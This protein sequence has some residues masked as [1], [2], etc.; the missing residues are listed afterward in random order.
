[1]ERRI[2]NFRLRIDRPQLLLRAALDIFTRDGFERGRLE[3][4][5][6]MAG[7]SKPAIYTHFGSKQALIEATITQ[8]CLPDTPPAGEPGEPALRR[9]LGDGDPLRV[10]DLVLSERRWLPGL[11]ETYRGAVEHKAAAWPGIAGRMVIDALGD[12]I[13]T[14]LF[15]PRPN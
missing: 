14:H 15:A 13:A 6:R 2:P 5:A 12:V 7:V 8:L 11:V 1:M 4:I 10:L 9:A 3:D